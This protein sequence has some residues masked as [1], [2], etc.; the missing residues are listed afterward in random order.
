MLRLQEPFF[1]LM[2]RRY[3][4]VALVITNPIW[5]HGLRPRMTL[6]SAW[7]DPVRYPQHITY[8]TNNIGCRYPIDLQVPKPPGV[9]RIL[10]LGDS[11]TLGYYYDDT[12][13]AQIERRLNSSP[14]GKRFEVV[15]C[16]SPSY[17]PLLYYLRLKNQ[18]ADLQPDEVLLNVNLT[19]VYDDYWRY[20]PRGVFSPD[21]EPLA[22]QGP[23]RWRRR[24]LL[25]GLGKSYLARLA[26]T[27]RSSAGPHVGAAQGTLAPATERRIFDYYFS[28]PVTSEAW[29][30]EVGFCLDNISRILSFCRQR[31]IAVTVTLVPH[32]EQL[33]PDA[34]GKLWIRELDRRV[35]KLCRE[36]EVPFYSPAEDLAHEL[37][38]GHPL[39]MQSDMHFTVEGERTWAG[40]IANFFVAQHKARPEPAN[41]TG[42][43][44]AVPYSPSA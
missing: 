18:L 3:N 21:G 37:N 10:V 2:E 11:F 35:E 38:A 34:N 12:V 8:S 43:P 14:Q 27:V 9:R 17:S 1:H 26:W 36:A 33:Q 39:Y 15:N 29:Q 24:V 25:W 22:V 19:N 6:A 31:G 28:L 42:S 20:R 4:Y 41:L 32:K 7:M 13:A 16:A 23:A 5:D 40:L 30:R 44:A